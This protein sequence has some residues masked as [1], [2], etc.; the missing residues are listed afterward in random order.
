MTSEIIVINGVSFIKDFNILCG[1]CGECNPYLHKCDLVRINTLIYLYKQLK[2]KEQELT[3]IMSSK[4]KELGRALDAEIRCNQA[5]D[6]IENIVNELHYSTL[7]FHSGKTHTLA[8]RIQK[9]RNQILDIINKAKE[10][11]E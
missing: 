5:L 2:E 6:E 3:N 8:D 9:T 10:V 11:Q 1:T 4:F 7:Y